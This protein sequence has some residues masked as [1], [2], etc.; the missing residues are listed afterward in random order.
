MDT[1]SPKRR[2]LT[3]SLGDWLELAE[4]TGMPYV[5]ATLITKVRIIDMLEYDIP[6]P[7]QERLRKTWEQMDACRKPGTMLRWDCCASADLKHLMAHGKLPKDPVKELQTLVIDER[8]F[9]IASEYP[10][11]ELA[12]WQR[13]WI[14]DMLLVVDRYPVEYRAFVR[15]GAV[16]GI[17]SYYPQRALR[18]NDDE[19]RAVREAAQKLSDK[20]TGP[21]DW[22]MPIHEHPEAPG[23]DED[24]SGKNGVH[25]TADFVV[26]TNGETLLLEGGP[27]HFAGAHPCCFE[28]RLPE[29]VALERQTAE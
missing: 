24:L 10:R 23:A 14:R 21:L 16:T 2:F 17:S 25:F 3:V 4:R 12:I 7:H 6:G 28:G 9:E 27:P 29:G 18:R 13:P 1:D 19:I 5:P 11:D 8:I 20:L 15:A 22:P 26:T